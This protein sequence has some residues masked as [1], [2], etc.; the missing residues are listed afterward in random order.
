MPGLGREQWPGT[1]QGT[2]LLQCGP[3]Q[4]HPIFQRCHHLQRV[5]QPHRCK[6]G[7]A[8]HQGVPASLMLRPGPSRRFY[9][10]VGSA[11]TA[12]LPAVT[13][14]GTCP[15]AVTASARAA[16]ARAWT[17]TG[18]HELSIAP[19]HQA[20][21]L[22]SVNDGTAVRSYEGMRGTSL[23]SVLGPCG[24]ATTRVHLSWNL[25]SRSTCDQGTVS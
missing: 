12:T 11:R 5:R 20:D 17:L 24:A 3:G 4:W 22:L 21:D 6:Q 2:F 13:S 1:A 25:R 18:G 9:D 23:P 7:R 8:D 10:D 19:A 15:R 16:T 14:T